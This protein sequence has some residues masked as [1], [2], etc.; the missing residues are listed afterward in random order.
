[1][2]LY[3]LSNYALFITLQLLVSKIYAYIMWYVFTVSIFLSLPHTQSRERC[4]SMSRCRWWQKS[5]TVKKFCVWFQ[6]P[7][8]K[9]S[10]EVLPCSVVCPHWCIIHISR[11]KNGKDALGF[12]KVGKYRKLLCVPQYQCGIHYIRCFHFTF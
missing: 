5:C 4:S 3:K 9:I 8:V 12:N 10:A 2:G 6:R 7:S 1:M 11:V